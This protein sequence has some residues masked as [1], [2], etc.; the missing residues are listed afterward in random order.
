MVPGVIG[1]CG[2]ATISPT[3]A[4]ETMIVLINMLT[5]TND[6]SSIPVTLNEISNLKESLSSKDVLVPYMA[7]I[8]N[9]KSHSVVTVTAI[10]DYMAK[11]VVIS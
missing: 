2:K 5:T 4:D 7:T 3:A 6:P 9:L 1:P 10:E 8:S 11:L